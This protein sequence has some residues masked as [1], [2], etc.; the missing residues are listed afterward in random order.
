MY[1]ISNLALEKKNHTIYVNTLAR[2]AYNLF[3]IWINSTILDNIE[4]L[5]PIV[6]W[7]SQTVGKYDYHMQIS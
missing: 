2:L 4:W 3:G 7:L 1:R 5:C 6:K